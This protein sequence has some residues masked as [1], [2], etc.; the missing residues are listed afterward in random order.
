MNA[1]SD[2]NGECFARAVNDLRSAGQK[3]PTAVAGYAW[4]ID[5]FH[6]RLPR[7]PRHVAIAPRHRPTEIDG[8]AV[9]PVRYAPDATLPAHLTFALKWEGVDLAVLASLFDALPAAE[10]EAGIRGAP[11]SAY[12]RRIWFLYEWLTGR[13]LALPDAGKVKAV[14]VVDP[15]H[16][17]ALEAGVM[18]SRHRVRNNLPGTPAYC[19]MVRRTERIKAAQALELG[20]EAKRVLGRTSADVV[21]RAAAFLL[22][23]DSRA[24]FRIEGESPSHDRTERWGQAIAKAGATQLSRALFEYLQR[25]VIGDSR[26]VKLGLRSEGGFVGEHD[27]HTGRP[28]PQHISAK[29]DDVESLVE[30]IVSYDGRAV[31]GKMDPVVAA[32]VEA[33]GFVYVHPF[34]DGNGRLHRWLI[35]HVLAQAGF[36]PGGLVFPVSAVILREIDAYRKVLASYSKGLLPMIE[37]RPTEDNNVEVLNATA[38]W[39]RFFDATAH[40]EFLYECVRITVQQELPYEVAYL[41]A[42][43]SFCQGVTGIADMPARTVDLL[44]RFLRQNGGRLSTRARSKEF[45]QLSKAEVARVEVLYADVTAALPVRTSAE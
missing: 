27:R 5:T 20:D 30:G 13:Q 4:L 33:F 12:M 29:S 9:L 16:Q 44:H 2:A 39:Y 41:E 42:Y 26:F 11:T 17:V 19:P 37:W 14:D 23:S 15:T 22:L 25:V 34:E 32:A 6:L 8:W 40:A 43:D 38:A 28:L 31:T 35:H 1:P 18:S 45:Q 7:S 24:S 36:A 21:A 10:V 3:P